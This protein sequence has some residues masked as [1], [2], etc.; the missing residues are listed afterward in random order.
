MLIR[1]N[2]LDGLYVEIR[3]GAVE[4]LSDPRADRLACVAAPVVVGVG[5]GVGV[6]VAVAAV[7][8]HRCYQCPQRGELQTCSLWSPYRNG[9]AC[10]PILY[11]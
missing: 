9:D 3:S 2:Q 5:V 7:A 8:H 4:V 1:P 10:V 6:A 11:H